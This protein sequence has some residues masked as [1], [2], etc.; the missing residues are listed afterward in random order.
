MVGLFD[1]QIVPI[2]E[3]SDLIESYGRQ[4]GI[5]KPEGIARE[6][7]H[8][9]RLWQSRNPGKD[10]MEIITPDWKEYVRANI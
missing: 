7:L 3:C 9:A 1:D 6:M 2:P 4:H 5:N 8:A 10:V